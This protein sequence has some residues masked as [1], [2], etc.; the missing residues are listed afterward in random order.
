MQHSVK[1]RNATTGPND[2]IRPPPA[3]SKGLPTAAHT[4]GYRADPGRSLGLEDLPIAK[5]LLRH[6]SNP[7]D[8]FAARGV[9]QRP[10]ETAPVLTPLPFGFA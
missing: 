9:D 5:T 7:L 2:C 10:R 4:L 8:G 6:M 1:E 3:K